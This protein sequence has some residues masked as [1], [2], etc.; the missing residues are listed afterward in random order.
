MSIGKNIK[1]IRGHKRLTQEDLAIKAG[2]TKNALYNYE[3]GRSEPNYKI[4]NKLAQ[5]LEVQVEDIMTKRDIDKFNCK[6]EN[7]NSYCKKGFIR[8][9]S[10]K[11]DFHIDINK[12]TYLESITKNIEQLDIDSLKILDELI[13]K[14]K[15]PNKK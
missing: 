9:K 1:R 11:S 3:S 12:Y 8:N 6:M 4:I 15:I 5:V 2:I 14:L 13:L 10:I 7:C